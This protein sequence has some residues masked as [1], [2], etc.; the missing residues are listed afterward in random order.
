MTAVSD[1]LV[2]ERTVWVLDRLVALTG[3]SAVAGFDRASSPVCG[4]TDDDPIS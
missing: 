1:R 3:S 2:I 4:G